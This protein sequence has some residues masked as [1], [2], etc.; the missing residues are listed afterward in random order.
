MPVMDGLNM[1]KHFRHNFNDDTV[2]IPFTVMNDNS[3]MEKMTTLGVT[4]FISKP[5]KPEILLEK[6]QKYIPLRLETKEYRTAS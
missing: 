2:V 1:L 5:V 3:M 4:D 6:L